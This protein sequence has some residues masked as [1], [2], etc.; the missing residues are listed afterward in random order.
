M[1]QL[2]DEEEDEEAQAASKVHNTKCFMYG[3]HPAWCLNGAKG[4]GAAEVSKTWGFNEQ[5]FG[6]ICERNGTARVL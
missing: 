4:N 6:R 3:N 5:R 1:D 2:D